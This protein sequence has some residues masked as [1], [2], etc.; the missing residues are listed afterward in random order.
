V[1]AASLPQTARRHLGGTPGKQILW[2]AA[3]AEPGNLP[4]L[5]AGLLTS[6]CT[7]VQNS[8]GTSGLVAACSGGGSRPTPEMT[9]PAWSPALTPCLNSEN[10]RKPRGPRS[11]ARLTTTQEATIGTQNA[12][13]LHGQHS[14][15][16]GRVALS[17]RHADPV[18][19]LTR[20]LTWEN[21]PRVELRRFELLT[22]CMPC[23]RS[24]N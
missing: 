23:K 9:Q 16:L 19:A 11:L 12:R 8:G 4:L 13:D 21:T 2:N 24:T 22:S 10:A 3:L 15:P 5:P 14:T 20:L 18:L 7:D 17:V 1:R 6:T